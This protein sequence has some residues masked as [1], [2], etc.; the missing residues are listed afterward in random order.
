MPLKHSKRKRNWIIP[1]WHRTAET[2]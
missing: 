1:V 2:R